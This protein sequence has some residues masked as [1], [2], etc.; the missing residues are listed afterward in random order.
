MIAA[1]LVD[2]QAVAMPSW[3]GGRRPA[4]LLESGGYAPSRPTESA[5]LTLHHLCC[6]RME[7]PC[8]GFVKKRAS[9]ACGR[10]GVADRGAASSEVSTLI[11]VKPPRNWQPLSR[12]SYRFLAE[13]HAPA[14][15]CL[16]R[17]RQSAKLDRKLGTG[18]REESLQIVQSAV[19]SAWEA[20]NMYALLRAD[21]FAT[22]TVYCCVRYC[23]GR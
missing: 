1:E 11:V 8:E 5:V 4:D 15:L 17:F 19:T 12:P 14:A 7:H 20:G 9:S 10:Q 3:P 16:W 18:T 21:L 6:R 22:C 23:T 2:W 13:A